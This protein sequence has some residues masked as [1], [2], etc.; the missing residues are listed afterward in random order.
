MW[1]YQGLQQNRDYRDHRDY[2]STGVRAYLVD[3]GGVE[4]AHA[5]VDAE[6]EDADLDA[7]L[8]LARAVQV[9]VDVVHHLHIPL[10][11]Y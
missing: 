4:V 10:K 11:K 1:L 8:A 3:V 5:R 6:V 2:R 9:V 7:G